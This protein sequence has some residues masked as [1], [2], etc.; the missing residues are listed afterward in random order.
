M[1]PASQKLSSLSEVDM[2][3]SITNLLYL[4]AIWK[5]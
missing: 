1:K 4:T 5:N 3:V 2:G